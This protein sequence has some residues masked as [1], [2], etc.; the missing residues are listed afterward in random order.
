MAHLLILEL[1]GGNDTDV[2]RAAIA[3]GDEVTFLTS[4]L[5][6]YQ[7]QPAVR[8]MLEQTREPIEVAPFD[9]AEVHRRVLVA[10]AQRRIDAL[11][12]LVDTRIPD[13]A[14]LAHAG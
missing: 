2:I 10:H 14:R 8:A 5:A 9:Y 1:P 3:R 12:C 7:R 13:A 6:H 11:L 4:D